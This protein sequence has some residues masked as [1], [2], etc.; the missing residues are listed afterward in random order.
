VKKRVVFMGGKAP[1]RACLEILRKHPD[2]ELIWTYRNWDT[3]VQH[4]QS[5][6]HPLRINSERVIEEIIKM[7]PD[8]II[9]VYYDQILGKEII[10]IPPMGC[11]NLH[12]A[13]AEEYRGCYPTTWAL[14][15][16]EKMT[17]VTLHYIDEGIDTGD[18]IAQYR[19]PIY[20]S[21][22]GKDL[23][24]RCT[25]GGTFLF[26]NALQSILDGTNERR[27]QQAGH[28]WYH[29]RQFPHHEVPMRRPT[30]NYIRAL[31]FPPYPKPYI[32]IGGRKFYIVAEEDLDD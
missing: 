5:S 13:L 7:A 10:D 8:L 24:D 26:E 15:N 16:G 30:K 22:T 11:I 20:P 29:K 2:V 27:K 18:I 12:L 17:G 9:V 1:G 31:Y 25:R 23:Y 32:D 6:S 19:I 14:I 28:P 21:D 3:D 4:P